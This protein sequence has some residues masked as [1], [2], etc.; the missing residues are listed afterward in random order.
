MESSGKQIWI[1]FSS[2][3]FLARFG[4]MHMIATNIC[5]WL[6]VLIQE[7]K[8]QIMTMITTNNTDANFMDHVEDMF[9]EKN[10]DYFDFFSVKP[11]RAHLSGTHQHPMVGGNNF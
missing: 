6:H 11:H 2:I 8:H 9:E 5:V 4:L 3:L 10:E 7:T 1:N